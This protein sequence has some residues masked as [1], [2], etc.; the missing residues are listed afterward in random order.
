[1]AQR[2]FK[3]R[4]AEKFIPALENLLNSAITGKKRV[5]ELESHFAKL[6]QRISAMGG[7]VVDQ[8][9]TN[10]LRIERET[11]A[12]A[13]Q[14]TVRQI[15]A[16]GCLV[17]DLD[18]GLIDFPCLVDDREIYLCW[19]LGEP[20][21]RFWHHTDEGYKSRKPIDGN[22]LEEATDEGAPN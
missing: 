14:E 12:E 5:E 4:E 20:N 21:I 1:M 9:A 13:L 22:L 18:L 19:K 3:L 8:E 7:L 10:E 16:S 15:E 17:K 6:S 11:T 2:Y